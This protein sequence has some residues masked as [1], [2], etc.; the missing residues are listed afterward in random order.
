VKHVPH[1]YLPGPWPDSELS[2][3]ETQIR[4]LVTVLRSEVGDSVSYTDG[5]GLLGEGIWNGLSVSRGKEERFPRISELA[6][7]VAPP[8]NKD[9]TRFVV[10]KLAELG[11]RSLLWLETR[12][13]SGRVPSMAKQRS[14]AVAALEQ[15]RGAWMMELG[16]GLVDWSAL[17]RPLAV[18]QRGGG[19]GSMTFKTVAVGPEGGLGPREVPDD[20]EL[21]GLGETTLRV[22]TASIVAAARFR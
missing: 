15:S 17:A 20:A 5:A 11:V 8:A 22:E 4:H 13:G 6:M 1:L 19:G 9:R 3:D 21:V 7:A 18:C 14:W 2:P 10:E 12:H 16:P